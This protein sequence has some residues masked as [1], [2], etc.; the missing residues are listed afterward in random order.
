M[1]NM[2][3]TLMVGLVSQVYANVQTH[4]I[5]WIKHVQVLK[6]SYISIKTIKKRERQY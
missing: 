3:I 1:M 5:V 6:Y 4:Q 2:F